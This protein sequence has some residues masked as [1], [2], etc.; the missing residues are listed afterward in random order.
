MTLRSI[1]FAALLG[2]PFASAASPPAVAQAAGQKLA[3]V[4]GEGAYRSGAL[5]DP[6]NDAGL[7]ASTLQQMGFD[8]TGARDLDQDSLRRAF[9]D[10][11]QK[12]EAA[13]PGAVAFV[14]LA[15]YGLQYEGENYFVPVDATIT[16][17]TD[18]PEQAIRVDDL[19]QALSGAS[20]RASIVVLDAARANPFARAGAPLAGGLALATPGKDSLI[21]FNAAPDTVAPAAVGPYDVYAQALAEALPQPGEPATDLLA[22]VRLRVNQLTAGQEI[23]WGASSLAPAPVLVAGAPT[24]TPTL[25]SAPSVALLQRP[26]RQLTP[27]QAYA[28]AIERDTLPVYEAF[29]VAFPND[30]LAPRVRALLAARREALI[31]E[32]TVLADRA[33]AYWTYLRRYPRGP[34]AADARRRLA[35]LGAALAPPP[36]FQLYVYEGLPP[37]PPAEVEIVDQGPI[38]YFDRGSYAPPPPPPVFF[39]PPQPTVFVNLPPPPRAQGAFVLPVPVVVPVFQGSQPEAGGPIRRAPPSPATGAGPGNGSLPVPEHR[40]GALP[41][42]AT[43]RA[44]M[45]SG[46]PRAPA[47]AE[48]RP[49]GSGGERGHAL[50]A[51]L[52]PAAIAPSRERRPANRPDPAPALE[53]RRL[54]RPNEERPPALP[55]PNEERK[56]HP[57]L[58]R[59]HAETPAGEGRRPERPRE[60]RQGPAA[61][62]EACGG[63]GEPPCRR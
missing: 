45:I 11:T 52:A 53:P 41:P 36:G 13:G 44:S 30:P 8:V 60:E 42:A 5:S 56:L 24:A 29:L 55:R 2:L 46:V 59:N 51:P 39:L 57:E 63:R 58:E 40:P 33:N 3:L 6:A 22:Q 27:E 17:A 4:V 23:P 37:P 61:L 1:A 31:W 9:R 18:V 21:A 19:A 38:I 49:T 16:R 14:Y 48:R 12:A 20:L 32:R 54:N 62:H 34:H 50:P 35:A 26:F 28:V 10:F 7:V 15:G 43:G 47:G 25:L